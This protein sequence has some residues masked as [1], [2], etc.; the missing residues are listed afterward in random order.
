MEEVLETYFEE[1]ESTFALIEGAFYPG[2]GGGLDVIAGLGEEGVD[3]VHALDL[4]A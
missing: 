4:Q 3:G 1:G 2:C